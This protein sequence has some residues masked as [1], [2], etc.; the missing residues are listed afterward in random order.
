MEVIDD[1]ID[2]N[3]IEEDDE[4]LIIEDND[5]SKRKYLLNWDPWYRQFKNEERERYIKM[6]TDYKIDITPRGIFYSYDYIK[7]TPVNGIL[8]DPIVILNTGNVLCYYSLLSLDKLLNDNDIED[9]KEILSIYIEILKFYQDEERNKLQEYNIVKR[10]AERLIKR[11]GAKSYIPNIPS[12][13]TDKDKDSININLYKVDVSERGIENVKLKNLIDVSNNVILDN[14]EIKLLYNK[15]F[16]MSLKRKI[17]FDTSELFQSARVRNHPNKQEILKSAAY[18]EEENTFELHDVINWLLDYLKMKDEFPYLT[19][20]KYIFTENSIKLNKSMEEEIKKVLFLLIIKK[21]WGINDVV[22]LKKLKQNYSLLYF[23]IYLTIYENDKG[24]IG[25]YYH[26]YNDLII[27]LLNIDVSVY[28]INQILY[29]YTLNSSLSH[30]AKINLRDILRKEF[31]EC[32]REDYNKD[33]K[34]RDLDDQRKVYRHTYIKNSSQ[35]LKDILRYTNNPSLITFEDREFIDNLLKLQTIDDWDKVNLEELV[36]V[37]Y[38]YYKFINL[39]KGC[40]RI[41]YDLYVYHESVY[42]N[43]LSNIPV[44]GSYIEK[45]GYSDTDLEHFR[46]IRNCSFNEIKEEIE[47]LKNGLGKIFNIDVILYVDYSGLDTDYKVINGLAISKKA[48]IEE[49]IKGDDQCRKCY[50]PLEKFSLDINHCSV[51]EFFEDYH[52]AKTGKDSEGKD[53][54]TLL[55]LNGYVKRIEINIKDLD[56]KSKY[57]HIVGR[58]LPLKIKSS[59]TNDYLEDIANTLQLVSKYSELNSGVGCFIHTIIHTPNIKDYLS[60]KDI[61]LLKIRWGN[62]HI[63]RKELREFCDTFKV[64]LEIRKLVYNY[65]FYKENVDKSTVNCKNNEARGV[66]KI[67]F[68]KYGIFN[69]YFPIIKTGITKYCCKNLNIS[70]QA[71]YE[72]DSKGNCE[73]DNYEIILGKPTILTN[74]DK[75]RYA[76]T[77]LVLQTLIQQNKLESISKFEDELF[78]YNK[79]DI[80]PD[81]DLIKKFPDIMTEEIKYKE[82]KNQIHN[83]LAVADTETYFDGRNLIPFCIC[84]S[85]K[86][87]KGLFK[88]QFYGSNCQLDFLNYCDNNGIHVIYF[89]NLKFDGWLFKNF[90]IRD[91][92]YHGG[93]LYQIKIFMNK[94]KRKPVFQLRDSLA[95][96]PTALRNFPK[97]FN[98]DNIE[99]E[100]Y[101]YDLVTKEAVDNN[102]I[103]Y[104]QLKEYFKENYNEFINQY[105]KNI[106]N[107]N[108]N[109]GIDI[110]KLTIYYCQNDCDLLL[111]GLEHFERLCMEAFDNINPLDYL[112]ISSYSYTIMI[113]NCFNKLNKYRGDIKCYIRKSIRGGRCM[114]ADNTKIKVEGEVVDFDACSLYPSAMKRLYL[115]TGECYCCT[116]QTEV[117]YLFENNLM[118]EDQIYSTED[119]YI[120]FMIIHVKILKV[121]KKRKFPLLSYHQK[122]I[123]IYTNEVEG[124]EMYLTSIEVEDFLKYQNG[125]VEFIDCIYWKGDKDI[126]MSQFIEKQYNLRR[127]YKK[128]GN[129]IQEVLKLFM[130]SAYGKTIQKDIKEEYS[131][132]NNKECET[133][134]KHNFGR[135]KEV[136]KLNENSYWVKLEGT[137][138]PLTVPCHIGALILGMSKRIMNE[139]ICTAEDN[140]IPIYYQDTDSIHMNK[141]DVIRLEKLFIEKYHRKLIGSEMGQFHIDFPLVKGKEPVSKRSIFLGK[142]AYLDCLYN[143]DGDKQYF[144]R[145]KGVPE[146]VI[147]NTCDDMEISVEELYERMYEGNE[148]DFNL[149]NSDK[150]KFEFTKDFQIMVR[151]KFS[152]KVKF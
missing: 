108:K 104:N 1:I 26:F 25:K 115:P 140:D 62:I 92:I 74:K 141:N 121:N 78:N 146:D 135:I 147:I 33:F 125:E 91:M 132:K 75:K 71:Y 106:N 83:C 69:H 97:M 30:R 20:N 37:I 137:K 28:Y 35:R 94:G 139:V 42:K 112:T 102:F 31:K 67:G 122:C 103:S 44:W 138:E 149:L 46:V 105:N 111:A 23:M 24:E 98:L 148:I 8:I 58:Y 6:C 130:N 128:V 38:E 16:T 72:I 136:I 2:G 107:N 151:E 129:P 13:V 15:I 53:V 48:L 49:Y 19:N 87:C 100:M 120:S 65:K 11:T 96:I 54:N 4:I 63:G 34:L 144:I 90:M 70:N 40:R 116:D 110:K 95:L 52:Q 43:T 118:K 59:E 10:I 39:N 21:I 66:I 41:F 114:V 3:L 131:F 32:N 50:V 22:V 68:I 152:R 86:T 142:K 7:L 12:F 109:N 82:I 57:V 89:H 117:K 14:N 123:N 61:E 127:D 76:K 77:D 45:L 81:L 73:I 60:E 29:C 113:K 17:D 88:H 51:S 101:P 126:R 47:I 56:Y 119:K 27:Y 145:M 80:E 99:K 150:P 134:L 18:D 124:M 143:E 79:S 36:K 84:L 5:E 55:S 93:R 9:D 64:N 85:Y 133:F